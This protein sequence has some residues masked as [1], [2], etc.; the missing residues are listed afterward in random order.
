MNLLAR[1]WNRE[2]RAPLNLLA[3]DI[4]CEVHCHIL[5]DG[6]SKMYVSKLP[7]DTPPAQ[8]VHIVKCIIDNAISFGA[9]HGV[10]VEVKRQQE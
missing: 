6:Q 2:P 4:L 1:L 7:P 10:Q 5:A 8:L 3:P 9:A